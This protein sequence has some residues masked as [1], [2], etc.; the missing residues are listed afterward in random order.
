MIRSFLPKNDMDT[1]RT[2]SQRCTTAKYRSY[3][4]TIVNDY[5]ARLFDASIA[6]RTSRDGVEVDKVDQFYADFKEDCDV[7]G[8]DLSAFMKDRFAQSLVKQC[9]YWIAEFPRDDAEEAPATRDQ[10]LARGLDR[11]RITPIDAEKVLDWETDDDGNYAWV[12][13]HDKCMRRETPSSPVVCV[14][15][16]RI[17]YASN[18][19]VYQLAYDPKKPPKPDAVVPMIDAYSHEFTR[20]PVC[21]LRMP[22]GMWLLDRAA[23]AQVEHFLLSSALSWSLKKTAYPVPVFNLRDADTVPKMTA[24]G[25]ITLGPEEKFSWSEAPCTSADVLREEIKSQKDEIF[26]V[27]QQMAMS[28][29]NSAASLGRSGESKQQ[30]KAATE[31]CLRGYATHVREAIEATYELVSDARGDVDITFSVE[32]MSEFSITD[33]TTL[34]ENTDKVMAL[35][36]QSPTLQRVL[37]L[38]VAESMLPT[39]VS[40]EQK[41]AIRH[42]IMTA[43]APMLAPKTS[44]AAPKDKPGNAE[45]DDDESRTN[46]DQDTP[47]VGSEE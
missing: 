4:G 9:A 7:R 16:W 12:K 28:I 6:V 24:G 1:E 37:A 31:V 33:T 19:E 25:G 34:V 23:D 32:G 39:G 36:I 42:E 26:R 15:T 3:V 44:E 13:I 5:A 20:V 46:A 45:N 47:L 30:D 27:S 35:G 40:Q 18:V 14:E 21:C 10:W 17:F 41:D 22:D 8:T 43:K 38:R 11:V 2:Y 29:E